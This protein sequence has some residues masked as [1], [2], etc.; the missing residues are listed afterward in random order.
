MLC[1]PDSP[2]RVPLVSEVFLVFLVHFSVKYCTVSLNVSFLTDVFGVFSMH[3]VERFAFATFPSH[4]DQL[5]DFHFLFCQTYCTLPNLSEFTRAGSERSSRRSTYQTSSSVSQGFYGTCVFGLKVQKLL[6]RTIHSA[7]FKE[8]SYAK[9]I[10]CFSFL[11]SL[12][13]V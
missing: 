1:F 11:I 13:S 2:E 8:A 3:L 12:I 6:D 9:L 7:L 4:F 5:L 10:S